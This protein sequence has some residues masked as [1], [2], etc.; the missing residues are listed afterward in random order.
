MPVLKSASVLALA[1][2]MA[3]AGCKIIKT[4]TAEEAAQAR[5][6]GFNPDR[7]VA[8]IWDAKVVP[9]FAGKTVT[10]DTVLA[11]AN[12]DI[13]AAGKQYGHREK[14]GSGPWT[15]AAA[16]NGAIVAAETK[17]RSAYVDV[18][19][20]GDGK[21]DARV[22]IGPA[23]RGTAIRDSLDFV[24]FNEFRNQIEW[25]QFGKSFNTKVNETVL[26][27]LPRDSLT[28]KKIAAKGAFPMPAKGQLP[29]FTP[30]TLSMEN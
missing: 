16:L 19:S 4:P 26:S 24:N 20:N 21:P 30:V 10:L 29:L 8:E 7:A 6:D 3:L 27:K 13:E 25:A 23:I 15:F 5:G 1:C 2:G 14:Q 12:T 9:F 18:D 22:Q 17:S 11:A 28:G